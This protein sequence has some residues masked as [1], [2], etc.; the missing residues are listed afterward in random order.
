MA[1]GF[2]V[3]AQFVIRVGEGGLVSVGFEWVGGRRGC[4]ESFGVPV[5]VG[6]L[7]FSTSLIFL[8]LLMEL[9]VLHLSESS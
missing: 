9:Y 3:Q 8:F 6:L 2:E 5:P 4:Q 7:W 1:L